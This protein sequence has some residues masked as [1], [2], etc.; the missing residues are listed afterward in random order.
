M[1]RT[2]KDLPEDW[3]DINNNN[4]IAEQFCIIYDVLKC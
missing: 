2:P 3:I 1:K 4:M